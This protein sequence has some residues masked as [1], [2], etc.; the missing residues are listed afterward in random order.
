MNGRVVDVVGQR[1][2]AQRLARSHAL[3]RLAR[4]ML[5]ELRLAAKP[6]ALGQGADAALVGPLHGLFQKFKNWPIARGGGARA[7]P[8]NSSR[9]PIPSRALGLLLST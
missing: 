6:D 3:Q 9:L 2:L 5:S 8:W 4:L 1:N 7:S